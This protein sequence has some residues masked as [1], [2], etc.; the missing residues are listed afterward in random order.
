MNRPSFSVGIEEEYLIVD[1]ESRNLVVEPD[2]EFQRLCSELT[3]ERSTAE[4]LQCQIEVGTAPHATVPEA[5]QDLLGL[6]QSVAAAAA[7]FGYAPIAASTH[8]FAR[9]QAQSHTRKERYEALANDLE[10]KR[11]LFPEM[12]AC[13]ERN[14]PPQQEF[15]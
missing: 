6:R 7:P 8:P 11:P 1:R 3:G 13:H 15:Y 5:E 10:D 9:W 4:F 12:S 14:S 2:P